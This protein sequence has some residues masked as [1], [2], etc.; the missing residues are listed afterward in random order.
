MHESRQRIQLKHEDILPDPY[1]G[2]HIR[3]VAY[4]KT[5]NA[6]QASL[7]LGVSAPS[8]EPGG[9]FPTYYS[10]DNQQPIKGTQ[11]WQRHELV[12]DVPEDAYSL[13]PWFH[14]D[15][16]LV[17][18]T[19]SQQFRPIYYPG[20]KQANASLH[21]QLSVNSEALAEVLTPVPVLGGTV[22][23]YTT[24]AMRGFAR[25]FWE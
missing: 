11:D 5:E 14:A 21:P 23:S 6:E 8:L 7:H 15:A 16:S 12:I 4:L 1:R 10:T 17:S 9:T 13:A 2:Q 24:M 18:P 3:L 19:F 22:E 20:C 25:M